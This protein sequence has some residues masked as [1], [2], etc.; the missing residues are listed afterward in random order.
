[1]A[2]SICATSV[3]AT[4]PE[5]RPTARRVS[6]SRAVN[7]TNASPPSTV[8]VREAPAFHPSAALFVRPASTALTP[9][10]SVQ[11]SG[12]SETSLIV[13][14]ALYSAVSTRSG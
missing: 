11:T 13:A 5:R 2:K 7:S 12:V 9:A 6:V 4:P 10:A 8:C 14:P 1:M 3:A